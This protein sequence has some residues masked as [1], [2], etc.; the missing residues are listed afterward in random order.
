MEKENG[1]SFM[2]GEKPYFSLD[3]YLKTTFG[4]KVYKISLNGGMSCPNRDGTL[5]RGGCIFCSRGGSGE[6]AANA[7]LPIK[8]QI[9]TAILEMKKRK[10]IGNSYIAYFQAYTNTYAEIPYLKKLYSEALSHPDITALSIATRPDCL[11]NE[12][13]NLL[14]DLGGRLWPRRDSEMIK[15]PVWIELGLQTIHEH[16][17]KFIRR[18]YGL[19]VFDKAVEDLNKKNIPVIVHII[20]GLPFEDKRDMIE[21]INYLNR[22]NIAGVKLQLMHILSGTDLENYMG[23]FKILSMEE[24]T[25]LVIECM[26]HLSP[27]TVIHRLTGDG[28]RELLIAPL[29][30]T[31]KRE[32]LNMIHLKMKERNTYQGR[33]YNQKGGMP[34]P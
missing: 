2:Y 16:T 17:A 10:S 22:K 18:A 24:Y 27:K 32:V 30:S 3:Y 28:P 33:L 9:N 25:D 11:P 14:E 26:E 31:K 7:A 20:L 23:E 1:K 34:E 13:L 29:W 6:F 19:S 12:V 4:E 5:G 21:T 8:E 15:K